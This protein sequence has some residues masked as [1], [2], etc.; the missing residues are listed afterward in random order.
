MPS[1][2]A[3]TVVLS[4]WL[5]CEGLEGATPRRNARGKLTMSRKAAA[6]VFADL[7][8]PDPEEALAK[9]ELAR[10][11]GETIKRWGLTQVE[12]PKLLDLDRLSTDPTLERVTSG[13]YRCPGMLSSRRGCLGMWRDELLAAEVARCGGQRPPEHQPPASAW[14]AGCSRSRQCRPHWAGSSQPG[15]ENIRHFGGSRTAWWLC[16]LALW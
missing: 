8:I 11:S 5:L 9:M 15:G 16:R 14:T 4:G 3:G 1:S 13:A 10:H 7:G 12:S 6:N 2:E